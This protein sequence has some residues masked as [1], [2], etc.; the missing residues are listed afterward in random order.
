MLP[1]TLSMPFGF[2]YEMAGHLAVIIKT[3][4]R[5]F[6]LADLYGHVWQLTSFTLA[7]VLAPICV[8]DGTEQIGF[9]VPAGYWL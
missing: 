2:L 6:G 9:S 5:C 8:Y 1:E 4:Y 7:L 3:M